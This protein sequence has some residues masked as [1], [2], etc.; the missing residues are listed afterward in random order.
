MKLQCIK[1]HAI[2]EFVKLNIVSRSRALLQVHLH[3]NCAACEFIIHNKYGFKI[4]IEFQ[5]IHFGMSQSASR[6]VVTD[7]TE[8]GIVE[9]VAK[10]CN[11]FSLVENNFY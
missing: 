11:I 1:F 2:S 6:M 5:N 9:Q 8:P 7:G 4:L 10:K 3:M